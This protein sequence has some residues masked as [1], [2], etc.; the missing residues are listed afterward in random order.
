MNRDMNRIDPKMAATLRQPAELIERGL[1]KPTE[2]LR[3]KKMP[4]VTPRAAQRNASF[5]QISVPPICAR[6]IARMRPGYGA[7][8]ATRCLA[9]ALFV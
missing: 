3:W 7:A 2:S 4:S 9:R 5:W 6:F 8:K 1:A